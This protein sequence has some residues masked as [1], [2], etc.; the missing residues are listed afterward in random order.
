MANRFPIFAFGGANYWDQRDALVGR[1]HVPTQDGFQQQPGVYA[2]SPKTLNMDFDEFGMR[3]RKGSA[4]YTTDVTDL[5]DS[6]ETLLGGTEYY[7][8][9][10]GTR[11]EVVV[12]TTHIFA[13]LSG[14]W[15]KLNDSASAEY[16]H[17]ATPAK[18][19]FTV[20]D[21]HLFIGLDSANQIQVY[22]GSTDLDPELTNGNLYEYAYGTATSAAMTGTWS[23][24]NHLVTTVNGRLAYSDGNV[25]IE[26]TP[27]GHT[28][29]SGLW[30]LGG[31]GAGAFHAA[32]NIRCLVNFTP[33][34]DNSIFETLYIG[35]SEGFEMTSG[36]A[37]TDNLVRVE[38]SRAPLNHKAVCTSQNWV[39]YMADNGDILGI[40]GPRVIDLGRRLRS[41]SGNGPLDDIS[42]GDSETDAWA[43]YV[44]D[45][46]QVWMAYTTNSNY[47]ND[48]IAVIDMSA[49]EPVPGEPQESFERRVRVWVWKVNAPA[50]NAW[51]A[52][53]Y[54]RLGGITGVQTAGNLY[55][56]DSGNSDLG[57]IAIDAYWF[58]P[59]FN[60]GT[61]T[62]I[63]QWF[64]DMY[65]T[66]A[67]GDWPLT[68]DIY[69][70]R[71]SNSIETFTYQQVPTGAELVG[72]AVIGEAVIGAGGLVKK[73]HR[74]ARRSEIIQ[75]RLRNNTADQTFTVTSFEL[76]YDVGAI[77]A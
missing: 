31:S 34:F 76:Q 43:L 23:D 55:T 19:A 69:T 6:G 39:V 26:Y 36:F 64:Q 11:T 42:I 38:G 77:A 75:V 57:T 41:Q 70:D 33:T 65:R 71:D 50:T 21:G 49:G 10:D 1:S 3:K 5:L 72:E 58:S 7:L 4:V 54:I 37:A 67:V 52:H 40:N 59:A 68:V 47:E 53:A 63:K 9:S 17:A 29:S 51:F 15:S 60:G 44:P 62:R 61:P 46:K 20:A 48:T 35:T 22:K 66:Y 16:G 2:E 8:S 28:A 24:S 12:G 74:T 30:D 25:L 13:N 18:V 45:K 27:M 73:N 56:M 14:T 32:G